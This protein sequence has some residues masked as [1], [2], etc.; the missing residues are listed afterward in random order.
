MDDLIDAPRRHIDRLGDP[1]LRDAH[2]LQK[3]SQQ[4]L[5][6]MGGCEVSHRSL[7]SLVVVDKLDVPGAGGAPCETNPPLVIDPNA[8]LAGAVAAQLLQAVAGWHAKV[9]NALSGIDENKLVVGEPAE[10]PAELLDVAAMPDRLG[11]LIP[12]RADH[13]PMITPRVINAKRYQARPAE[14]QRVAQSVGQ[15]A[16]ME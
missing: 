6:R 12:D 3:L 8:V 11:V 15:I 2:R 5:T 1:I 16:V 9:V 4:D 14:K 13:P 7:V 10:F